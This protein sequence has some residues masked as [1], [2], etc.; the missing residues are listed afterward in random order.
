MSS[1]IRRSDDGVGGELD[2]ADGR[3]QANVEMTG[4]VL[5]DVA[6]QGT[7]DQ[8]IL[9]RLDQVC[10]NTDGTVALTTSGWQQQS[11]ANTASAQVWRARSHRAL[12]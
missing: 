4:D 7:D 1:A 2:R 8:C 9:A 6:N 10:V 5:A 11:S 12:A 3:S